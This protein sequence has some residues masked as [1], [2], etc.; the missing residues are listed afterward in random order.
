MNFGG[1]FFGG[2]IVGGVDFSGASE[3]CSFGSGV[4]LF[5][6]VILFGEVLRGN[7]GFGGVFNSIFQTALLKTFG[8]A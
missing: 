2:V 8:L 3:Q 5:G 1:A 7:S 4:V 6:G